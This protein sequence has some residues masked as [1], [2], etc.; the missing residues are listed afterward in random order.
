MF[1]PTKAVSN[2]AEKALK[3][4]S[5]DELKAWSL[6]LIPIELQEGILV[7]INEVIC[8]DPT[9]A[10]I[11]TVFTI[12]WTNGSGKG[13]FAIPLPVAEIKQDDLVECFPVRLSYS[14]FSSFF[15]FFYFLTS[16]G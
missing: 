15:F 8:G 5:I 11:D 12:V 1:N 4:K 13:L 14:F 2:K 16:L 10:P 6:A 9:C 7:D 3:K